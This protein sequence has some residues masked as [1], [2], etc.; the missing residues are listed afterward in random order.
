M[1]TLP[2]ALLEPVERKVEDAATDPPRKPL[3]NMLSNTMGEPCV[4]AN[5]MASR[6][7]GL[8]GAYAALEDGLND[9]LSCIA[10]ARLRE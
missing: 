1:H 6:R 4:L 8:D 10:C 3:G 5:D 7:S 2:G 9:E